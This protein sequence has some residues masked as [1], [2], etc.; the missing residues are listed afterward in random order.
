MSTRRTRLGFMA[1]Y[2]WC[3][4]CLLVE[5]Q[6]LSEQMQIKS[7]HFPISLRT[8]NIPIDHCAHVDSLAL[9]NARLAEHVDLIDSRS[10]RVWR[11]Q[12]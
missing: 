3:W 8:N 2:S 6:D 10:R 12:S 11:S 7:R 1:A 9:I 4:E 5:I